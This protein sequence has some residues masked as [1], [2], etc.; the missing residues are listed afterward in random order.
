MLELNYIKKIKELSQ[1]HGGEF[2][3]MANSTHCVYTTSQAGVE[4]IGDLNTFMAYAKDNYALEDVEIANTAQ[5]ESSARVIT[6][7][8]IVE[9]G[10]AVVY[11]DFIDGAPIRTAK[12]PEYGTIVIEL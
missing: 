5:F 3:S 12:S 10:H 7:N 11:L 8:L 6:S 9:T 4:C 1:T 2:H